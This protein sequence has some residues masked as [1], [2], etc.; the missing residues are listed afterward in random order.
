MEITSFKD[1]VIRAS[2]IINR[3]LG[4]IDKTERLTTRKGAIG[5]VVEESW[6]DYT[7][8]NKPEADFSLL[9][10]ELKVT[11]YIYKKIRG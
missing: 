6:F 2:E 9:G 10:I 11:P 5:T 7:P 4:D 3:K 8:N 1:L